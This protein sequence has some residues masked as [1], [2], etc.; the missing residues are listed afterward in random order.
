MIDNPLQIC[1]L[2]AYLVD[3]KNSILS[4]RNILIVANAKFGVEVRLN[5]ES[6][7]EQTVGIFWKVLSRN[8]NFHQNGRGGGLN[9]CWRVSDNISTH[10]LWLCFFIFTELNFTGAETLHNV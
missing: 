3:T 8:C 10:E 2:I 1:R 6:D 4:R 9:T 5:T 7:A